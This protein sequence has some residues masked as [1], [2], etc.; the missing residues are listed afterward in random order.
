MD[1]TGENLQEN[2]IKEELRQVL[3]ELSSLKEDL[4]LFAGAEEKTQSIKEKIENLEQKKAEIYIHLEKIGILVP[5][6]V[7]DVINGNFVD[8]L[9]AS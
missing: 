1:Q 5:T 7:A 2:Q 8:W 6:T 3:W 9:M 4:E